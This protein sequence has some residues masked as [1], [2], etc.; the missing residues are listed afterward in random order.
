MAL[1]EHTRMKK[2]LTAKVKAISLNVD[3]ANG[4]GTRIIMIVAPKNDKEY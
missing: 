4:R 1:V 2:T 3:H